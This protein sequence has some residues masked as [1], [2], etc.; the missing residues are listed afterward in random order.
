MFFR[1]GESK[2]I[3][4][5]A[6][7]ITWVLVSVLFAVLAIRFGRVRASA[8]LQAGLSLVLF[9]SALAY[10]LW[11][12]AAARLVFLDVAAIAINPGYSPNTGQDTVSIDLALVRL[13]KPLPSSFKAVELLHD[14]PVEIG[15]PL[16]IVGYGHADEV[17]RGTSGVLRT[18][19]LAVS[20][21]KS[22][23]LIR[24]TDPEDTGLG[25]C[26]GDS[27]GPVFA[28]GRPALVAVAIRAKGI[29]GYACGA[30]TEAVLAG[31]QWP[32][33]HKVL[34]AWGATENARTVT[35]CLSGRLTAQNAETG[36]QEVTREA[37]LTQRRAFSIS[38]KIVSRIRL[39]AQRSDK[40]IGDRAVTLDD[41][42][43]RH[44]IDSPIDRDP[45]LTVGADPCKRVARLGKKAPDVRRIVL[46]GN[47]EQTHPLASE[48]RVRRKPHHQL[49]FLVARHAPGGK[50]IHERDLALAEIRV[51]KSLFPRQ[52]F[53]RRQVEGRDGP[54][55]E[56]RGQKRGIA[57]V[58][59]D[60]EQRRQRG[61]K[62]QR[63]KNEKR[64]PRGR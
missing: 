31:P 12:S 58:K 42:C 10:Y 22:P 47:P 5:A 37:V 48:G 17:E 40:A 32:W 49:M 55:D 18:A 51:G 61:E 26:T 2:Q 53:D 38:G 3:F 64:P 43:L 21:P 4:L 35:A 57:R 34:Q 36:G 60:Q 56:R 50:D 14:F 1:G 6:A 20:G 16:R 44:A 41:K 27:G 33:I 30:V 8:A 13:A 39:L 11:P 23:F 25:G 59:P 7:W 45:P 15:Q 19:V 52:A 62:K 28:V 24:L 63:C 9:G 54:A 29:D 46:I